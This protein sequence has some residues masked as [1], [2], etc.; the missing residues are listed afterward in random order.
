MDSTLYPWD[1][2]SKNR[3]LR[4][5]SVLRE[6]EPMDQLT[7]ATDRCRNELWLERIRECRTSGMTVVNWC[8]SND[9]NIK[10]Y[11]YWL[12]KLKRE[13][14]EL[15]PAKQNQAL[16]AISETSFAEISQQ[17]RKNS[18]VIRV[19]LND[20]VIE[21]PDGADSATISDVLCAVRKLC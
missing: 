6:G 8:A 18:S 12:R 17:V 11:Y 2:S 3:F 10:S 16:P 9:I 15:L 4:L 7:I 21:I 14:F 19:S 1:N 20:I 13:A 5:F